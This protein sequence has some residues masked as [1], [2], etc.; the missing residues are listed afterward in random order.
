MR[1]RG[2]ISA[3]Y[4][5]DPSVVLSDPS[6]DEEFASSPPPRPQ[7]QTPARPPPSTPTANVTA[8]RRRIEALEDTEDILRSQLN[9]ANRQVA[10]LQ[11]ISPQDATDTMIDR[12]R[13]MLNEEQPTITSG[14]Y[15]TI[16]TLL[17][18]ERAINDRLRNEIQ[19]LRGEPITD[20]GRVRVPRDLVRAPR[21]P[22]PAH[23]TR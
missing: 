8:L 7:T 4:D 15:N 18:T 1:R 3:T 5:L 23:T 9:T 20:T 17:N 21:S 13:Q 22:A 19:A 10:Q 12:L 11:M 2:I 14:I 6:S 16:L